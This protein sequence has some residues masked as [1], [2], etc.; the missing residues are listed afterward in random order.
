MSDRIRTAATEARRLVEEVTG[1][2]LPEPSP[3]ESLLLLEDMSD[4]YGTQIRDRMAQLDHTAVST[5]GATAET[6]LARLALRMSEALLQADP[7]VTATL[8]RRLRQAIA[9][10]TVGSGLRPHR[11]QA[12]WLRPL[13]GFCSQL[14]TR[15]R[16]RH[17]PPQVHTPGQQAEGNGLDALAAALLQQEHRMLHDLRHLDQL[18]EA[19][20][21]HYDD[22]ALSIAAASERQ[23]LL[24]AEDLVAGNTPEASDGAT[25]DGATCDRATRGLDDALTARL[26]KLVRGRR[27][28]MRTLPAIR[29]LQET[30]KRLLVI[31]SQLLVE[32][33]PQWE[34]QP[35]ELRSAAAP[36]SPLHEIE[37]A[38][39]LIVT[40]QKRRRSA[41]D[42]LAALAAA[43]QSDG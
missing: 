29:Q 10:D 36:V 19:S 37:E 8:L 43:A 21:A 18:Y 35:A 28:V 42:G 26:S 27:A 31:I 6:A 22:L 30:D 20:L 9:E 23:R 25:R 39:A 7:A 40:S 24:R 15:L 17:R 14:R 33:L 16:A 5:F 34:R 11:L 13:A 12:R 3:A 41:A 2:E 32:T 38:L 4:D 1:L